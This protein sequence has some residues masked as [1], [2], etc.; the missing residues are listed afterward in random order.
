[1][2]LVT[3]QGITNDDSEAPQNVKFM[4]LH[5]LPGMPK[6]ALIATIA[7]HQLMFYTSHDTT[8]LSI[9]DSVRTVQLNE[10]QTISQA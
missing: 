7:V 1:M 10:V 9:S 6:I 3:I 5:D 4:A 8:G 2:G